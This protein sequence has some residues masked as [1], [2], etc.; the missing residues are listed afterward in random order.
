MGAEETA[1]T[2]FEQSRLRVKGHP[3]PQSVIRT[4]G[5]AE[6]HQ[7][8]P[9]IEVRKTYGPGHYTVQLPAFVLDQGFETPYTGNRRTSPAYLANC[10]YFDGLAALLGPMKPNPVR[11]L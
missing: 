7:F 5:R 4:L 11:Y 9:L 1:R 3:F 8:D 10:A 2:A 6:L